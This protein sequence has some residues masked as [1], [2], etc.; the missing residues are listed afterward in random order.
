MN[1]EEV[2]KVIELMY[3]ILHDTNETESTKENKMYNLIVRDGYDAHRLTW[4]WKVKKQISEEQV[5]ILK[6]FASSD[7]NEK[8]ETI[9][10]LNEFSFKME[11]VSDN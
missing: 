10:K 9:Y 3:G 5:E 2:K 4:I 8:F 1:V 11:P 7:K 6:M